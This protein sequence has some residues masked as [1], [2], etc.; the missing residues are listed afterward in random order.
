MYIN[1]YATPKQMSATAT[2]FFNQ[3]LYNMKAIIKDK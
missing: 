3:T 1:L 2:G